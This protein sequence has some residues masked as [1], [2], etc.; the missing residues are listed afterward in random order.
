MRAHPRQPRLRP[1]IL[2]VL[3]LLLSG[4]AVVAGAAAPASAATTDV[5][6]NEVESSDG[7]SRDWIEL[8]NVGSAAVD[9]SG[10]VLMDNQARNLPIP[11]G[12]TI[13]PG[14]YYAMDVDD[15]TV[16]GQFGLGG[17]D[18]ARL[19]LADGTTV[20]DTYTWTTAAAVTYGRCPDGTGAFVNTVAATKGAA[21]ACAAPPGGIVFNEVESNGD[22]IGDFAEV[23]N[24]S[25]SPIDISGY[26]FTDSEPE[27][28]GHV[29]PVPAGTVVAAGGYFVLTE[30]AFGFGLGAP[31]AV[32]LLLP[33]GTT[34][35]DSYAWT[36]H[37]TTTY[38]R[39]PDQTGAIVTT[40]TSTRGTANDCRPPI[41]INEIESSGGTPGDWVELLNTGTTSVDVGGFVFKDSD[42]T[43]IAPIAL[44]TTIAAGAYLVLNENV[45]FTFGLGQP[46]SARLYA[47]DG[48]TLIDSYAWTTHATTTYG[49]CPNGTGDLTTTQVPTKGA[50]NSCAGD[51]V[52]AAW[53][54]GSTVTTVDP[55][56]TFTSNL[57]GLMYEPSGTSTAGTIWAVKNGP[58]TLYK[59]TKAGSTWA[60]AA[61]EW[62]A[63]KALT[64]PSGTGDVDA[65]GVTFTGAGPSA[66]LYVASERDNNDNSVSRPAIL[67]FDPS[68]AG[69]LVATRDW[70]LTADL[71]GLGANL[72]LE[73]ISWVPDSFLTA[74]GFRTDA[75]ATYDPAAYPGHGDG[76]FLVG[77]EATG[78]VYAY[79]LDQSS[80][81]Y[82]RVASFASG[83]PSVMELYVEPETQKLWVVCD[84]TCQGRSAKF[85][86]TSA[87]VFAADAYYERPTGMANLNNE[88]FTLAPRAECVG[89][90]KPA[91]WSDDSSTG[92]YAL[93]E[94]TVTCTP[95]GA[96]EVVI[97]STPP[98][99]LVV[100]QTYA[101]TATGGASGN[102]VTFTTT[103]PAVCSV[104][105]ATVALLAP[106]TCVL[107][108]TQA[109]SA[110][111]LADSVGQS[112]TVARA[113]TTLALEATPSALVARV[114]VVAPGVAPIVGEVTFLVDGRLAGTAPVVDG[115]ATLAHAVAPGATR[116]VYAAYPGSDV[117]SPSQ[118]TGQRSD[119]TITAS[120]TS[121]V[122]PSVGGWYAA[123]VTVTFACAAHGS[124]L[125]EACP[126]PVVLASSGADQSVT[127]SVSAADGGT[128]TV[129]VD[130]LDVDLDAPVVR[131][132][133]VDAGATYHAAEPTPR[134]AGTDA[135]SGV[136][137]C[138]LTT[139]RAGLLVTVTA[140]AT[141]AADRTATAVVRYRVPAIQVVGARYVDGRYVVERG[142]G[143]KVRALLAGSPVP[144]LLG[145]VRAAAALTG[146]G[147][148]MTK[149]A[150][151]GGLVTWT[152]SVK[153][154]GASTGAQWKVGVKVGGKVTT[155]LLK[156][157]G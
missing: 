156:V 68:G 56:N 35:V 155:V 25:G 142:A 81:S 57:S 105:G 94:G 157:T 45:D 148:A 79:A 1:S 100:G 72:G 27:R 108:A 69:P 151:T 139:T 146:S 149:G 46:D 136:A 30:A 154:P 119:P 31:D 3:A 152:R 112:L 51:I 41:K 121:T 110:D 16:T 71:P 15:P 131:I 24:T 99:G 89:G 147:T 28:V 113:A 138:T 52:A 80:N 7:T 36:A 120:V 75:G 40:T 153:V 143:L 34:V 50:L 73:A 63:G 140:T 14:G 98:S 39:C 117:L 61:G 115:V 82:T 18:S 144:R 101:L 134:C 38:G 132:T 4:L 62:A 64:Y 33:D 111:H 92:G 9:V 83:F 65:E 11:A 130:D 87:G 76:L 48:T 91:F 59:L 60:P 2:T 21:N 37:A 43:H 53:P 93:R 23:A 141:D 8:T 109:G 129:T 124:P 114:A 86:V 6:I 90:T 17:G 77:V 127:R 125:V 126:D 13:A 106:G 97:T 118:A 78:R 137:S 135:T 67:R 145:P 32:R 123:P 26:Q 102:P 20:V 88:G 29:Y 66:G 22:A 49:R 116:T 104:S 44:G 96:Q 122:E 84:D 10:W 55:Q 54:G 95:R 5:K 107:T 133:G 47:A 74:R 85:D 70:N 58:G 103:S 12:T 19:F 150:A 42:D 128:G